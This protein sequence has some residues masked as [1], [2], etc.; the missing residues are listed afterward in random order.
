MPDVVRR[1]P[2]IDPWTVG[3]SDCNSCVMYTTGLL[4][5]RSASWNAGGERASGQRR[6]LPVAIRATAAGDA[7]L[8]LRTSAMPAPWPVLRTLAWLGLELSSSVNA[9]WQVEWCAEC[10]NHVACLVAAAN[11]GSYCH[12][13]ARG[14]LGAAHTRC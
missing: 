13:Y 10:R 4:N 2:A 12:S 1:S 3:S 5:S 9:R 14:L 11:A 6:L 8:V 7:F